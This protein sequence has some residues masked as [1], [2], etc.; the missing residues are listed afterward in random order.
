MEIKGFTTTSDGE[1]F[2]NPKGLRKSEKILK[3]LHRDLL[4]EDYVMLTIYLLDFLIILL[5]IFLLGYI[6]IILKEKYYLWHNIILINSK[7]VSQNHIDEID[8]KHFLLG[9]VEIMA[10]DEIKIYSNDN[11]NVLKGIVLGA[12]RQDNSLFIVTH[13]DKV[14]QVSIKDIRNFKIIDKYGKIFKKF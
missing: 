7:T 4:Q 9:N 14:E 5:I 2:K 13:K 10:G 1:V 6:L 3:K 8:I 11:K 12:K